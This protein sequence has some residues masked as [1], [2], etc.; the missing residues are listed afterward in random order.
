[1]ADHPTFPNPTIT[2]ALCEI[3]FSL[4]EGIAWD[5]ATYGRLFR[6]IQDEFPLIQ[7]VAAVPTPI[8]MRFQHHTRPLLIHLSEN[9]LSVNQLKPYAGWAQ[10]QEDI[11]SAWTYLRELISP[12][13]ITRLGLRYINVVPVDSDDEQMG[14]WLAPNDYICNVAL[15]NRP[16]VSVCEV[17]ITP[18][19]RVVVRVGEVNRP[20]GSKYGFV[21][22]IDAIRYLD[23]DETTA[24][25]DLIGP[26]HETVWNVFSSFLT[27]RYNRYLN[28]A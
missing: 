22:D 2:E 15:S 25:G 18:D 16:A 27:E 9:V 17:Q 21:L 7:P 11:A 10:M 13:E 3:H 4:P 8:R 1:M 24:L 6:L 23:P 5:P 20:G 19:T 26:L 12:I 14:E 28:G